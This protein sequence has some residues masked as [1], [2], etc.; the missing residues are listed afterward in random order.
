MID[1]IIILIFVIFIVLLTKISHFRHR[2][3]VIT[4]VLIFLFLFITWSIVNAKNQLDFS[5]SKGVMNSIGIY[6][7]WLANSFNNLKSLTGNA[8]KMDWTS[9]NASFTNNS[10]NTKDKTKVNNTVV[11]KVG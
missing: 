5:T 2:F 4:L 8:V 9:T 3:F 10:N 11:Y 6:W 1:W 7:G